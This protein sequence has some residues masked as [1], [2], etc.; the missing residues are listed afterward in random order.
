MTK[1]QHFVDF[2]F[3]NR[4]F[5]D[6]YFATASLKL[7]NDTMFEIPKVVKTTIQSNVIIIY[8]NHC[9]IVNYQPPSTSRLQM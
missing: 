1:V 3:Q 7:Q 5:E 4:Y 8:E 9:D 2:L 6:S